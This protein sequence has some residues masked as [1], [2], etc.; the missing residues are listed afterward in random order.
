MKLKPYSIKKFEYLYIDEIIILLTDPLCIKHSCILCLHSHIL[1]TVLQFL[2]H[3]KYLI[4][5]K[6]SNMPFKLS[7][8]AYHI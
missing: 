6:I 1:Q 7:N 3:I 8:I 2:I 5:N 4:I